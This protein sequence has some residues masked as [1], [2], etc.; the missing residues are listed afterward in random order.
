[1][2]IYRCDR[3]GKTKTVDTIV[4]SEFDYDGFKTLA[5]PCG[6]IKDVCES[7]LGTIERAYR[8]AEKD[9]RTNAVAAMKAAAGGKDVVAWW[10]FWHRSP[11]VSPAQDAG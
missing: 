3:C 9:G 7:C 5:I 8:Q 2:K 11:A 4:G 1:M 10:K 6:H